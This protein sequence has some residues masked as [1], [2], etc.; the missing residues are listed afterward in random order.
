VAG[1]QEFQHPARGAVRRR[2]PARSRRKA[3]RDR[4]RAGTT[5]DWHR[6]SKHAPWPSRWQA[7]PSTWHCQHIAVRVPGRACR[8]VTLTGSRSRSSPNW[9]HSPATSRCSGGLRIQGWFGSGDAGLRQRGHDSLTGGDGAGAAVQS[10]MPP[11][12]GFAHRN[13]PSEGTADGSRC[14]ASADA[15]AALFAIARTHHGR[16][17]PVSPAG[18][19]PC[20][21]R[22]LSG[23]R[24]DVI[25][26]RTSAAAA[27]G[28]ARRACGNWDHPRVETSPMGTGRRSRTGQAVLDPSDT[29]QGSLDRK[30]RQAV[31]LTAGR[32]RLRLMAVLLTALR[33]PEPTAG[34]LH[35][36]ASLLRRQHSR[37]PSHHR[38]REKKKKKLGLVGGQHS[39]AC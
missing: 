16:A 21:Y 18:H 5:A 29:I 3:R 23:T 15:G 25:I 39:A 12:A 24:Y 20:S 27:L 34:P 22:G 11:T 31:L 6:R 10:D 9:P 35:G 28:R 17:S 2:G 1:Q 14:S 4:R 33:P 26:R 19:Y 7:R 38:A 36:A 8:L 30:W 37:A 32:I 13:R